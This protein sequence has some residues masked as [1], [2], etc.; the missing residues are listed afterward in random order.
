MKHSGISSQSFCA[1]V[2]LVFLGFV[3]SIAVAEGFLALD[4]FGSY[5]YR[6][7]PLQ[8]TRKP[9]VGQTSIYS[10][11]TSMPLSERRTNSLKNAPWTCAM[12][13]FFWR[14]FASRTVQVLYKMAKGE[15]EFKCSTWPAQEFEMQKSFFFLS[16]FI[17]LF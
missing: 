4:D 2:A 8:R 7:L 17:T 14:Q 6:A 3:R 13:D 9:V 5:V 10:Y 12:P 1:I 16:G 11:A 15:T